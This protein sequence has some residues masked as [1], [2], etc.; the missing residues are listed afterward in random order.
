MLCLWEREKDNLLSLLCH[1]GQRK[2]AGPV[3][4]DL[5]KKT[6]PEFPEVSFQSV[7]FAI[8]SQKRMSMVA[9]WARVAVL[10]GRI[11]V[12]MP[13]MRPSVTLQLMGVTA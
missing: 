10:W 2:S 9:I 11:S 8:F 3:W 4:A 6:P 7:Y 1:S 12:P 13:L 5:P